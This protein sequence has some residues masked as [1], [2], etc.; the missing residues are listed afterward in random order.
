MNLQE[1]LRRLKGDKSYA[2]LAKAADCTPANV[3]KIIDEGSQPSFSIGAALAMALGVDAAWLA[4][5]KRDWPPPPKTREDKIVS[6]VQ[7]WTDRLSQKDLTDEEIELFQLI[8]SDLMD[9]KYFA[10]MAR[11]LADAYRDGMETG[12]GAA[13]IMLGRTVDQAI[14]EQLQPTPIAPA[15]DAQ[16][17]PFSDVD[18]RQVVKEFRHGV[19]RQKRKSG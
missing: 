18:A 5:D 8:R 11:L 12:Q 6:I 13:E 15:R 17:T 2:D 14:G 16:N 7:E 9:T 10:R 19:A 4:D 1:K 3:R